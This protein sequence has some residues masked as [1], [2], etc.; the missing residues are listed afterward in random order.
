MN[1][2][3]CFLFPL[4]IVED[5]VE[6]GDFFFTAELLLLLAAAEAAAAAAEVEG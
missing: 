5:A 4:T 3:L 1:P 6:D 2:N